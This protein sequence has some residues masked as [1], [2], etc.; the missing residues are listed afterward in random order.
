MCLTLEIQYAASRLY[1]ESKSGLATPED[2]RQRTSAL[3]DQIRSTA[4][5]LDSQPRFSITCQSSSSPP[6]TS[7]AG[8]SEEELRKRTIAV[9]ETF[10]HASHI[11]VYRIA[12][13]PQMPLDAEM[14]HSLETA[15]HLLT[16]VPDTSG[17]GANLGWCL[18]VLGAEMN[19]E[20][21]RDYVRSRLERLKLL[22]IYNTRS[23][24]GILEEV[25][26]HADLV[27]L[28]QAIPE[29]WQDTMQRIGQPQI[30]V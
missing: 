25:W 15:M 14:Q 11:Y 4:I 3:Q 8:I 13:G 9:A 22:G 23:G 5:S 19:D 24:E 18:V 20:H 6:L 26:S 1:A 2:L 16:L 30:L 17:P 29:S 28:G 7:A 27:R 10:R 12:H 21:D